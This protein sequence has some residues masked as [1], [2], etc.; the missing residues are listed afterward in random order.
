M[1]GKHLMTVWPKT[2]TRSEACPARRLASTPGCGGHAAQCMNQE[3]HICQVLRFLRLM[4]FSK[5]SSHTAYVENLAFFLRLRCFF[6]F[7]NVYFQQFEI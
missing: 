3:A 5:F 6:F 4:L 2:W 1:S 7:F